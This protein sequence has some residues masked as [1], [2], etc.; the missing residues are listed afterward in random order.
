MNKLPEIVS[1]AWLN[2]Q[3]AVVFS[4]VNSDGTPNSIYATSVSIYNET[5]VLIA[6]NYFSKTMENLFTGSK[7]SILFITKEDKS[8]QIKGKL[9]YFTEG[10]LF[11]DM[12]K[13]NPSRFPG[14]GVAV[15]DIEEVFAGA[16]KLL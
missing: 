2:K 1:E 14:H 3:N 13:W 9:S 11:D 6:N 15:L 7:G 4:T 5:Q 16:Q 8:F 12:K 10:E